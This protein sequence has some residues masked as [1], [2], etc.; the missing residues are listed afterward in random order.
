MNL[1]FFLLSTLHTLLVMTRF[2]MRREAQS[3]VL[4]PTSIRRCPSV[5]LLPILSSIQPLS[6]IIIRSQL[7]PMYTFVLPCSV[8]HLTILF[9]PDI[10]LLPLFSCRI[11]FLS[12]AA[13]KPELENQAISFYYSII[14]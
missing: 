11:S 5:Y 2:A 14:P 6:Y 1:S 10:Y 9:R 4:Y 7:I 8:T 3:L 12:V 13:A